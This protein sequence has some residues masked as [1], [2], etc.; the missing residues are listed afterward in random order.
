LEKSIDTQLKP[1][2]E[3]ISFKFKKRYIEKYGNTKVVEWFKKENI[4]K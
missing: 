4:I 2:K 3:K 1:R